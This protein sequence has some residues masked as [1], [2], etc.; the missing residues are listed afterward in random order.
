M[1]DSIMNNTRKSKSL[2]VIVDDN[3]GSMQ[4]PRQAY[5]I[6]KSQ[7]IVEYCASNHI[8]YQYATFG[9]TNT[10]RGP[11]SPADVQKFLRCNEGTAL[12][13][14]ANAAIEGAKSLLTTVGLNE[15]FRIVFILNT[16][17]EAPDGQQAGVF[18]NTQFALLQKLYPNMLEPRTFVM[19]IGKDHDQKVLGA[20][21]VGESSYFNYSDKELVQMVHD[22]NRFLSE[23]APVELVKMTLSD[24]TVLSLPVNTE[25]GVITLDMVIS[26]DVNSI[27]MPNGEVIEFRVEDVGPEHPKFFE[28]TLKQIQKEAMEL[29][30]AIRQTTQ[31]VGHGDKTILE[32]FACSIESLRGRLAELLDR[33]VVEF[34][35]KA[36]LHEILGSQESN[37]NWRGDFSACLRD[38]RK[39]AK[40]ESIDHKAAV[41]AVLELCENGLRSLKIGAKL[42]KDLERDFMEVLGS[43]GFDHW[44]NKKKS[45]VVGR[46]MDQVNANTVSETDA[47]VAAILAKM[48]EFSSTGQQIGDRPMCWLTLDRNDF[49]TRTG[50][51]LC[52]V[53][54]VPRRSR[55]LAMCSVSS[56][57]VFL[58][59][60]LNDKII[61]CTQLMSFL[62]L[63]DLLMNGS[64]I[65]RGPD[66]NPIN[67]VFCLVPDSACEMSID[68]ARMYSPIAAS[69]LLTSRP[70]YTNGTSEYKNGVMVG[71]LALGQD[72]NT[73]IGRAA[74]ELGFDSFYRQNFGTK[75]L[76]DTLLRGMKFMENGATTS[77]DVATWTLAIA[78]Q[79]LLQAH[80]RCRDQMGEVKHRTNSKLTEE[81]NVLTVPFWNPEDYV[82]FWRALFLRI[83]RDKM[84]DVFYAFCRPN[85]PEGDAKRKAKDIEAMNV[86]QVLIQ[87]LSGEEYSAQGSVCTE[88]F[89]LKKKPILKHV[90]VDDDE[91]DDDSGFVSIGHFEEEPELD[92]LGEQQ[93]G[94]DDGVLMLQPSTVGGMTACSNP[95]HLGELSLKDLVSSVAILNQTL[96]RDPV[97]SEAS[98]SV[99][100]SEKAPILICTGLPTDK[101]RCAILEAVLE[102]VEPEIGLMLN[103]GTNLKSPTVPVN[104]L[105]QLLCLENDADGL[106]W[107][108][109]QLILAIKYRNNPLFKTDYDDKTSIIHM[110]VSEM[111]IKLASE[112]NS[113]LIL[114]W[115][116]VQ[117]IRERK[118][119]MAYIGMLLRHR[120]NLSL[121]P[122]LIH[123]VEHLRE[124]NKFCLLVNGF[125]ISPATNPA[126]DNA[127]TGMATNSFL[128]PR[129][130]GF[131]AK[132][133]PAA[134]I[135]ESYG[136]GTVR[137]SNGFLE[138][139][140][141]RS[142]HFFDLLKSGD[143][144]Q[145]FLAF[146]D[147]FK[148]EYPGSDSNI[149]K[150]LFWQMRLAEI[151]FSHGA[152][153]TDEATIVSMMTS[154]CPP[155]TNVEIQEFVPSEFLWLTNPYEY[156]VQYFANEPNRK[157]ISLEEF[158][159]YSRAV[160]DD[161]QKLATRAYNQKQDSDNG[162][163]KHAACVKQS[164]HADQ[165]EPDMT[166]TKKERR[167]L[168]LQHRSD[169]NNA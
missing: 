85:D 152:A 18:F 59:A 99:D 162:E 87:G 3:S 62:T 144:Q 70:I 80:T 139:L 66:G 153:G 39:L 91:E 55:N 92:K 54:Y 65:T 13:E 146:M 81:N 22:T 79:M 166:L 98:D 8:P 41:R 16:D 75:F 69:L 160:S 121:V 149:A 104:S 114:E 95:A 168:K 89:C 78:D 151:F 94:R 123:G 64:E 84:G 15:V 72:C 163:V 140:H 126:D 109:G 21:S 147:L 68:I 29:V 37:P 56:S 134:C 113:K 35:V 122:L 50:D 107:L 43:G 86:L 106:E 108:L 25:T 52:L 115:D 125:S 93:D 42:S 67:T 165:I 5:C 103:C 167:A 4:G 77:G 45:K 32:T 127:W 63:R 101:I 131:F 150:Q 143:P 119:V 82:L 9:A 133:I 117:K 111:F 12:K 58:Q 169:K 19:G 33:E 57:K 60:I 97:K 17:G 100:G 112:Y 161:D 90:E 120:S 27:T 158:L 44:T 51:V 7:L 10:L 135:L 164:A 157:K 6:Q 23:L 156:L 36:K 159:V 124:I 118:Q 31:A 26:A 71:L 138:N 74:M 142:R 83:L 38:A 28:L 116:N 148:N 130:R 88:L 11:C 96:P 34:E 145:R 2:V 105:L 53:G 76:K 129:S 1:Y 154:E 47:K 20:M 110:P 102:Y 30:N 24:G 73:S 46:A 49:L 40:T 136:D 48:G 128:F 137:E 132:V 155:E 61:I 141:A 14:L